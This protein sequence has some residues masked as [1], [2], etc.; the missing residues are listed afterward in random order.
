MSP[1]RIRGTGSYRFE[2]DWTAKL[3]FRID[4]SAET[5]VKREYDALVAVLYELRANGQ[6]E[7]LR[8][9]AAGELPIGTLK[10]AKR[11][12]RLKSD[13]LLTDMAMRGRLWHQDAKCPKRFNPSAEHTEECLGAVDRLLPRMAKGETRRRYATS[14][15]K[16]RRVAHAELPDTAS[17]S[18]LARVD[19]RA[20]YERWPD[21][22]SDWNHMRR[23]V[24]RLLSTLL[25]HPHHQTRLDIVGRIPHAE[26]E[27]RV[28]ELTT[29]QFW[30]LVEAT[31]E[32]ARPC[33]VT[34]AVTGMR[35]G[36]Y[37]RCT[38]DDL[39]PEQFAIRVPGTKTK[40]SKRIVELGPEAWPWIT[41][42]IPSP[43]KS[44]RIH[45]Y[46]WRACVARGL[47]QYEEVV[48]DGVPAVKTVKTRKGKREEKAE[49]RYVGLRIHDLRHLTGQLATDEGATTAQVGDALGHSDYKTTARYQRRRHS[50]IVGKKV[51]TALFRRRSSK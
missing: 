51:S 6:I 15:T 22:G 36:E 17:V 34:L 24:S 37:L 47:G 2:I 12:G 30:R 45:I 43:L 7:I 4:R 46:W 11:L 31:P 14:L 19:W 16:L 21:S 35:L 9:F 38:V 18:G 49:V 40:R 32:H 33:Y 5:T 50:H 10:Q 1:T 13:T 42:G 26:E 25:G 27:E 29:E 8:R 3:G 20:L 23:A 44:R 39:I 28:P 41:A 48:R